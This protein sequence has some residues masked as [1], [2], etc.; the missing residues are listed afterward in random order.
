MFIRVI[1]PLFKIVSNRSHAL[2]RCNCSFDL[3]PN[4]GITVCLVGAKTVYCSSKMLLQRSLFLGLKLF[5][6]MLPYSTQSVLLFSYFMLPYSNLQSF[7]SIGNKTT[8]NSHFFCR[9]VLLYVV[10]AELVLRPS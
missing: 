4:V 6:E 8:N 3:L 2:S 1:R 7:P 5:F 10:C 9:F